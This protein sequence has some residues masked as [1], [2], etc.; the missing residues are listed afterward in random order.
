MVQKAESDRLVPRPDAFLT[1]T[2]SRILLSMFLLERPL[3][4]KEVLDSVD[5]PQSTWSSIALAFSKAGLIT[6]QQR[7]EIDNG[8][9]KFYTLFSLTERG[10]IVAKNL[11]EIYRKLSEAEMGSLS[12]CEIEETESYSSKPIIKSLDDKIL[13]CI[14]RGLDTFGQ[15]TMDQVRI[16]VAL[17]GNLNWSL[18]PKKPDILSAC[19]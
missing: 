18:V 7:R 11:V 8:R 15:S 1:A 3:Y 14:E 6:K 10:K 9:V 12:V 16:V 17:A 5:I 19:L 13:D 4:T 2:Q